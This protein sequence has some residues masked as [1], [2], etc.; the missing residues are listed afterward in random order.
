MKLIIGGAFQGKLEYA[1]KTYGITDGNIFE[2]T[3]DG[4][5]DLGC[6]LVNHIE[7]WTL[8]CVRNGIEPLDYFTDNLSNND[9]IFISDDISCGVVPVTKDERMWRE[10]NGRLLMKLSEKSDEVER[11]FCGI[12][13]RL[14]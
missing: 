1:K 8:W 12:A 7:K 4:K 2:C 6:G 3:D 13:Q 11:V 14:K 10:A 5:I 9:I